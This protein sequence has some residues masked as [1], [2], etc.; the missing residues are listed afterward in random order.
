[1]LN[2]SSS[3]TAAIEPRTWV[4]ESTRLRIALIAAGVEIVGGHE[5]QARALI[6]GLRQVG[7]VVDFLPINPQF[8]P[9]LRWL[10][11]IRYLRTVLNQVL[12]LWSLRLLRHADVVHVFSASYWSFLLA[13]VP[14]MTV[15][16]LLGKRIVLHY[17]SGEADDHLRNWGVLVHPWLR[18]AHE[19]AV[20]SDYLRRVFAHY[21]YGARVIRNVVDTSKF[22]FRK[23]GP[24]RPRLLSV[25]N[26]E[27]H[28]RVDVTL[29]AFAWIK[30]RFPEATLTVAGVGS[31]EAALRQLA[32]SIS[33]RDIRFTGRVGPK[34]IAGLYNDCDVFLN[35]SVIDNQPVSILEAFAA[36]LPVITTPTGDIA[37]MVRDGETGLIVPQE[38]AEAMAETVI[39]LL[40]NPERAARIAQ[41]ARVEAERYTWPQ[42]CGAWMAVY[43]GQSP[44]SV[45]D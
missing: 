25:R 21:G 14:A 4:D 3:D 26:F 32:A 38:N 39:S 40:E 29:K 34:Q 19:I 6:A 22:V 1:M 33:T 24:L 13:P 17:H 23:R 28:Y 44:L 27:R 12:Y 11:R 42:V 31:E 20:P 41:Q 30:R 45:R 36:G 10:R 43:A 16:R 8:P 37:A 7:C 9:G 35:A 18:L 5:V 2:L 15:G